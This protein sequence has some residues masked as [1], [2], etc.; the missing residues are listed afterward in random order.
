[1]AVIQESVGGVCAQVGLDAPDGQVH[2]RHFPGGGVAVLA[3]NGDVVDVAAVA[4]HKFCGLN[5]HAAAAAAGI[6]HPALEG[7][8]H[9]HKRAHHAGGREK[10]ASALAFLLRKHGQAVFISAAQDVLFAAVLDHLD[11]GEQ[12]HHVAQAALIQFRPGKILGQNIL[13]PLVFFLDGAHGVIDHRA[14]FRGVGLGGN[15]APSCPGRHE[16]DALGGV[17]VPILLEAVALVHQRLV[18]LL[19]TVGNV[20]EKDQPKHDV[21]VF[22]CVHVSPQHTGRIPDLFFKANVGG[23]LLSHGSFLRFLR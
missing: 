14:D 16:K 7:L 5:K 21:F 6:V 22:R 17:L 4:L 2:L 19:K 3:V 23:V 9:L 10:F 13:E 8:Q 15:L 20:L 18:L 1:M 11:I 12:I